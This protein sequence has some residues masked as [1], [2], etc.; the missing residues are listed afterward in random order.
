MS[1]SL[2]AFDRGLQ[3]APAP[4]C[5]P[6]RDAT[7]HSGCIAVRNPVENDLNFLST[8]SKIKFLCKHVKL[9]L[10]FRQKNRM[11]SKSMVV[12]GD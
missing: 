9:I 7:S 2:L 11:T 1:G 8:L 5:V 12:H 10:G 6:S 4:Q 3:P